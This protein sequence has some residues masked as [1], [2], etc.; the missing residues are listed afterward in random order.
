MVAGLLGS[1]RCQ[2]FNDGDV[3]HQVLW[4]AVALFQVFGAVVGDPDFTLSIFGDE[5]FQREIDGDA[6]RGEHEGRPAFWI[7]EDEELGIRHF[8]S[9]F[10][11]LSTVV[12]QDKQLNAFCLEQ[13]FELRYGFVHR[14]VARL[15]DDAC[16]LL[17]GRDRRVGWTRI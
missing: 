7:A 8:Q 15:S 16:I 2:D 11:G 17:H 1:L 13:R 4:Q 5:Y 12:N 14:M 6:G 9:D 10:S 3:L